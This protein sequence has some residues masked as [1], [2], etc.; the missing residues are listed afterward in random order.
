MSWNLTA[1]LYVNPY[2]IDVKL[3]L[4]IVLAHSFALLAYL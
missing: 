1:N 2:E 3:H 4:L